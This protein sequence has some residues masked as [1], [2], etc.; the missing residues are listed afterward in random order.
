MSLPIR[1]IPCLDVKDGRVVKGV[2]F[3][4]LKDA[5]D[6]VEHAKYYFENGADELTFLDIDATLENRSTMYDLVTRTAEQVFIPLTVGGGVR[7][8]EDVAQLLRAGADKVSVSSAATADPNLLSEISQ[9]FGNQVLV[10]SL[11]LKRNPVAPGRW[12]VTTHGGR[13]LTDLDAVE[14]ISKTQSL[15]V[16]EFL[17]NSIDADGT[18]SGFDVD[19]LLEIRHVTDLPIIASGGAGSVGDFSAAATAGA[20]AILAASIFHNREITISET[21]EELQVKGFQVRL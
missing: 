11:D 6:V 9:R 8:V 4:D 19:L 17:V 3:K 16:G 10:L 7:K 5:G 12:V 13:N 14:W 2:N 1:I 20:D 18:K 21:K 15:G